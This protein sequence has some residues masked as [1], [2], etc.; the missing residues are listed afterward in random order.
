V[1]ICVE[2]VASSVFFFTVST[3]CTQKRVYEMIGEGLTSRPCVGGGEAGWM[4]TCGGDGG[5]V[6]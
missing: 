1:I 4:T 6:H 2:C 5:D 3:H